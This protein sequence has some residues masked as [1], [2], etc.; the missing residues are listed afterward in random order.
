MKEGNL[1]CEGTEGELPTAHGRNEST[2][3]DGT[4][5]DHSCRSGSVCVLLQSETVLEGQYQFC[6]DDR[7]KTKMCLEQ[8]CA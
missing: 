7:S 3:G 8:K 6:K 4:S 2:V 5:V 1:C